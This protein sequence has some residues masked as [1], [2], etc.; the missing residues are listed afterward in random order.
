[1]SESSG[2]KP[3][4]LDV[5]P[6]QIKGK[7]P[8]MF[9]SIVADSADDAYHQLMTLI[10]AE[11]YPQESRNGNVLRLRYPLSVCYQNPMNRVLFHEERDWPVFFTFFEPLWM[12]AGRNDVKFLD[13][14][15]SG[16]K[17][18]SDDGKT[19][20]AAYGHRWRRHFGF[21]QIHTVINSLK[22][23]PNS[24]RA[25]LNMWDP[26]V[27]WKDGGKDF[28]CNFMIKFEIFDGELNMW[29]FNR[30][31]DIIFGLA[32]ANIT[33]FSMLQ[34][35]IAANLGVKVGYY[36]QISAN[37]H[38][39]TEV[40]NTKKGS[41][42]IGTKYETGEVKPFP[43]NAGRASGSDIEKD[44]LSFMAAQSGDFDH[45]GKEY[46]YRE[47]KPMETI[48]GLQVLKPMWLTWKAYKGYG[49]RSQM[50]QNAL[51]VSEHIAASD[52]RLAVQSWLARR[53]AEAQKKEK[54]K[55]S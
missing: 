11:G 38:V 14:F 20:H 37:A 22:R 28:P 55:I 23:D 31:N 6:S 16:M 40:S 39:Y 54:E 43:M 42:G 45:E 53:L 26:K 19:F 46:G 27:D 34:E 48:W 10:S 33:Q 7:K 15:N 50:I 1:M 36:W 52:W 9:Y 18:Y 25:M 30:S 47:E 35:F 8:T 24:R 17:Q 51:E 3:T 2:A 21:D 29:V 32:T 5:L 49:T 41:S 12:I 13:Q 44:I 4:T